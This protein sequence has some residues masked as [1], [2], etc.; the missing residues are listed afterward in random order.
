[1]SRA[2]SFSG[3]RWW[4]TAVIV[5]LVITVLILP[6]SVGSKIWLVAMLAFAAVFTV[7]EVGAKGR[8]LAALMIGLLALYLALAFHRAVLLL[9]TGGWLP[10][11]L[12]V[13]MLVI[14]AVGTW[15]MVREIVFGAR[16]ERLGRELA[17]R[18]E[19][20]ADDLPRTPSGRYVR[21]AA[22]EHFD[23][24]RREVEAFPADWGGWYRLSLAYSASG[25]GRRA[26]RSM[27]TAIALHRGTNP[28][29]VLARSGR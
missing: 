3:L 23:V 6:I 29:T 7:L 19:L 8:I 27:R 1:M 10:T 9:G 26:R 21:A 24:V 4:A 17:A 13:A 28:E 25:D 2:R 15:A 16:T 12:G 11:L 14:P 18:G 20:P 5:L 22:D